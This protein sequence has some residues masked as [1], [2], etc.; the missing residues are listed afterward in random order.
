MST[1][2]LAPDSDSF[3]RRC[4]VTLMFAVRGL[5]PAVVH[6]ATASTISSVAAPLK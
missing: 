3:E 5:P 6:A 4:R 1:D 2:G